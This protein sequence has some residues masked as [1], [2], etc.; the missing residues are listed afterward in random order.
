VSGT[1]D[2][3]LNVNI[4]GGNT[5]AWHIFYKIIEIIFFRFWTLVNC[6]HLIT[7]S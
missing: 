3:V 1:V 6:V 7:G 2:F 5:C 4:S